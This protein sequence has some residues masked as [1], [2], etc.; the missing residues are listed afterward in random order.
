M[1]ARVEAIENLKAVLLWFEAMYVH[2]A[3]IYNINE[4]QDFAEQNME[5]GC[6]RV[7][8]QRRI[9]DKH[10]LLGLNRKTCGNRWWIGLGNDSHLGIV[11]TSLKENVCY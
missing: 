3:N 5:W 2:E 7:N 4:R 9:L 6:Q 1:G 11:N 10:L 8:C